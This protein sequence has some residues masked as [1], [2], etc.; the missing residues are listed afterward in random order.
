MSKSFICQICQGTP[1]EHAAAD[2]AYVFICIDL[3]EGLLDFEGSAILVCRDFRSGRDPHGTLRNVGR[4]E[5]AVFEEWT[6][7]FHVADEMAQADVGYLHGVSKLCA[8]A[9]DLPTD[10]CRKLN[11]FSGAHGNTTHSSSIFQY[12]STECFWS[13]RT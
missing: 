1:R 7:D 5:Q 13:D 8:S 11:Q 6:V 2:A 4:L 9:V 12:Q 3:D 10:K